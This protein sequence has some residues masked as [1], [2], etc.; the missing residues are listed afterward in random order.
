MQTLRAQTIAAFVS[1]CIAIGQGSSANAA[2]TTADL[3]PDAADACSLLTVAQVS[4]ALEET[5]LPGRPPVPG[6]SKSCIWSDALSPPLGER[7]ATLSIISTTAFA[8]AK[9]SSGRVTIL[10][11]TGIGDEAYYEVFK[12]ESPF[13]IARKGDAAVQIRILN[14][15]KL[16]AFTLDQEKTKEADL[17]KA[18][19]AKL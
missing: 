7:R 9:S 16:K 5:S 19:I 18:A 6:S 13:L 4:T 12:S 2:P 15:L 3:S 11:V 14:G 1:T 17:A 10:P 8:V